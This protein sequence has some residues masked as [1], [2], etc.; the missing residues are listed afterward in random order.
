MAHAQD[1]RAAR[2]ER[3]LHEALFG[4]IQVKSYDKITVQDIIDRADVGRST[5]YAHYETKD[6]LLLSSIDLLTADLDRFLADVS[7]LEGPVL[8]VVGLFHHVVGAEPVFRALFGTSGID[9]VTR[10]ARD[11]LAERA[12]R[13]IRDREAAGQHHRVDAQTRATFLA[14]SLMAYVGWWLDA[15]LPNGPDRAAEDFCILVAGA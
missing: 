15:G 7:G 13:T 8:P 3:A 9:L 11:V 1:R 12:L 2:T 14:G 5:F 4:L 6:D 10:T